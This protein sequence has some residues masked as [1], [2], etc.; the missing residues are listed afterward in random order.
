MWHL[1]RFYL[2]MLI[3]CFSLAYCTVILF[4]QIN[5]AI[6]VFRLFDQF[7]VLAM[8]ALVMPSIRLGGVLIAGLQGWGLTELLI[9]WFVASL[10]SYLVLQ[11]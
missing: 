7:F 5:V 6:G 8:R 2:S 11:I 3:C 10:A 9:V 1:G 4:R